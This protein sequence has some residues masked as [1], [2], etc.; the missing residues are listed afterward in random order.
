[1][2]ILRSQ[3]SSRSYLYQRYLII[4]TYSDHMISHKK[5]IVP[6]FIIGY[7][8]SAWREPFSSVTCKLLLQPRATVAIHNYISG[9]KGVHCGIKF[10]C[11][12]IPYTLG[13]TWSVTIEWD[14]PQ[15]GRES[16]QLHHHNYPDLASLRILSPLPCWAGRVIII[17]ALIIPRVY[18]SCQ[19]T[20][21]NILD[22]QFVVSSLLV[23]VATAV[24][25]D[26]S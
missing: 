18:L 14:P 6:L 24:D 11:D 5:A 7:V 16:T 12:S 2:W 8:V 13:S 1:M 10:L 15:S 21:F 26:L 9:G 25:L 23:V 4:N 17:L 19:W 20:L 3:F 22:Y